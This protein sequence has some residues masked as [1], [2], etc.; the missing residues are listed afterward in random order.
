MN[1]DRIARAAG[2]LSAT[3]IGLCLS[4][5]ALAQVPATIE[6]E[7]ATPGL[8]LPFAQDARWTRYALLAPLQKQPAPVPSFDSREL[9]EMQGVQKRLGGSVLDGTF[10]AGDHAKDQ[11]E[12][13][14]IWQ[15]WEHERL[16]NE[17]AQTQRV[18]DDGETETLPGNLPWLPSADPLQAA[19]EHLRA[20]ARNLDLVAADLEDAG[21]YKE[22]DRLRSRAQQIRNDARSFVQPSE[23]VTR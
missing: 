5:P 19:A 7:V 12:Q 6:E 11:A 22:A 1:R 15:Q 9:R 10:L 2:W 20:S 23:A 14:R 21:K 4:S 8:P 3:L 13:L 18:S 16:A 17:S